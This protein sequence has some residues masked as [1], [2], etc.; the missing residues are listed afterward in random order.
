MVGSKIRYSLINKF[1][2]SLLIYSAL[3]VSISSLKI[4]VNRFQDFDQEAIT[5]IAASLILIVIGVM[6]FHYLFVAKGQKFFNLGLLIESILTGFGGILSCTTPY[7]ILLIASAAPGL[8]LLLEPGIMDG[9]IRDYCKIEQNGRQFMFLGFIGAFILV[10]ASFLSTNFCSLL[11]T[12]LSI[13]AFLISIY[14]II[15]MFIINPRIKAKDEA[16]EASDRFENPYCYKKIA[17]SSPAEMAS[18]ILSIIT[19]ILIPVIIVFLIR[20]ILFSM[21]LLGSDPQI[22]M[23]MMGTIQIVMLFAGLMTALILKIIFKQKNFMIGSISTVSLIIFAIIYITITINADSTPGINV[24]IIK[25]L[26]LFLFPVVLSGIYLIERSPIKAR[27]LNITRN[28]IIVF[29]VI[30]LVA[31]IVL[32]DS[33]DDEIFYGFYAFTSIVLLLTLI[34]GTIMSYQ[35]EVL[36]SKKKSRE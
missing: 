8:L 25:I 35:H 23:Q 26:M 24:F 15:Q 22:N 12:A 11:Q 16:A 13:I 33:T 36:R 20:D 5:I 3:Y 19:L 7:G 29:S 31:G 18:A 30:L 10:Q 27:S 32:S 2:I 1:M 9:W 34:S 28:V 14:I 21:I 6:L 4:E 17:Q